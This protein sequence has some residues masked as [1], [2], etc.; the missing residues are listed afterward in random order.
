MGSGSGDK[1]NSSTREG[2]SWE[3][4]E[5]WWELLKAEL[6]GAD[7]IPGKA[8]SEDDPILMH[9]LK[10]NLR[11]VFILPFQPESIQMFSDTPKDVYFS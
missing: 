7:T 3:R 4:K 1:R 5:R 6:E 9:L 10:R 8:K 2:G 11:T